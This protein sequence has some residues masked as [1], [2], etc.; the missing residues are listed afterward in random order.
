[1]KN[2]KKSFMKHYR[3]ALTVAHALNEI[4]ERFSQFS[5]L[6][7]KKQNYKVFFFISVFV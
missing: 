4:L 6:W 1:M 2:P 5:R 7:M 3:K